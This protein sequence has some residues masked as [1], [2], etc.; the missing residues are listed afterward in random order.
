MATSTEVQITEAYIGLFGRAPDPAG[1]AYWENQLTTDIAAGQDPVLALKKLTNDM[2]L[3][4]GFALKTDTEVNAK[5]AV[6]TMYDNLFARS[7]TAS[8]QTYWAASLF[9]DD[10]TSSAS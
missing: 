8:E 6:N 4:S 3:N 9:G 1:L 7:A 2:T 10:A 5:A